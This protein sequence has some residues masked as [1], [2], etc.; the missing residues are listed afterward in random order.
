MKKRF[1]VYDFQNELIEPNTYSIK[2]LEDNTVKITFDNEAEFILN[3]KPKI[4][5]NRDKILV[6]VKPNFHNID[7]IF[8]VDT[9]KIN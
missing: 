3:I 6:T 7:D 4:N 8:L 9:I 2:L 1:A 5:S